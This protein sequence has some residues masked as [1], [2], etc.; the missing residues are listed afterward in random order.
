MGK[1]PTYAGGYNPTGSL[2]HAD[3][4]LI[5]SATWG[6]LANLG[7]SNICGQ[8]M[9]FSASQANA[10]VPLQSVCSKYN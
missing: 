6:N 3:A 8:N 10:A 9:K 1:C 5:Q 4:L 2:Q 7:Y